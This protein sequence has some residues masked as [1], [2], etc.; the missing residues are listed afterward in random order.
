[1]KVENEEAA[2]KGTS[3]SRSAPPQ[4]SAKVFTLFSKIFKKLC[5]FNLMTRALYMYS[6]M[7]EKQP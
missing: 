7:L 2:K 4:Q 3:G 1:M 5:L 6:T